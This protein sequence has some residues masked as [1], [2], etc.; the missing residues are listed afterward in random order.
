MLNCIVLMGRFTADP[1]LK[2]T[3]NNTAVT[4]FR[5]A[6]DR[7]YVKSGQERQTD[8][9]DIVAWR[10]NAEFICKHF[11]KGQLAVVQ[12][13]LQ[14]RSYTDKDGIK[15]RAAEVL[16]DSIYFAGSKKET[17]TNKGSQP[18]N[19]PE[20]ISPESS[21]FLEMLDDDFAFLI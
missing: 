1:E 18:D 15:R 14:I 10:S 19:L 16:A 4:E 9:I 6:V 13:S 5:L 7:S 21:D 3:P 20:N 12:G 8:F 2:H 17:E 11:K